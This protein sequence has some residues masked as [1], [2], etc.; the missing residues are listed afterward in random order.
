MKDL[1]DTESA[2]P[3]DSV[4]IVSAGE[5]VTMTGEHDR[6]E[7]IAVGGGQI[8]AV[9]GMRDLCM[10]FPSARRVEFSKRA[11]I[12]PGLN[13][14]HMHPTMY[15]E[16]RLHLRLSSDVIKDRDE[17]ASS[18]SIY[19]AQKQPGAWVK[20]F[21]YDHTKTTNGDVIDRAF[22]DSV[23]PDNPALVIH[24]SSHWAIAN[25]QALEAAGYD[26]SSDDPV[27]GTLGRDAGGRLNGVV[28]ENAL[29]HFLVSAP[30]L[31]WAG[32]VPEAPTDD[33]VES[34]RKLC[35]EF[36]AVGLTS[37][38]DAIVT[39]RNFSL[40][41]VA[42]RRSALSVRM[43]ALM[44]YPFGDSM[45]DLGIQHGFGSDWLRVHGIKIAVDGAITGGTCLLKEPFEG[46]GD[47]R[48]QQRMSAEE[49][50]SIVMPAHAAG[51]RLAFHANGDRAIE[52]VLDA[53]EKAQVATPND[54][55]H[56]IEHCT[57][58]DDSILE[59]MVKLNLIAVPFGAVLRYHG[60]KLPAW[61]G[62]ERLDRMFAHRSFIDHKIPVAGSS[63]F[64]IT[65]FDPR[66]ALQ[67]MVTRQTL[68][69]ETL[70]GSQ[71]I[72]PYE[73]LNVYTVGSAAAAGEESVKGQLRPGFLADFVVF[74]E[75]PLRVNPHELS[76]LPVL[77]TWVGGREVFRLGESQ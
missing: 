27:G 68:S 69:G 64:G 16:N 8:L 65:P 76:S 77:S 20:G 12:V 6:A 63:D 36:N 54:V 62:R 22:L 58:I 5:I 28:Y 45:I 14:A 11:C 26:D 31:G 10:Q 19:S 23:C 52:I 33:R 57:V 46:M 38:S 50:E 71:K 72:T 32:I 44:Y 73:A 42:E 48:G 59:R 34:L 40:L 4:S 56:R 25:T 35:A 53:I 51:I 75:S 1:E 66:L 21:Q 70:G 43:G 13:D 9:G 30:S 24:I 29:R 60:E 39:P 49:L 41:Q 47:F 74:A 55:R 61:Y 15:A 37:V 2:L 17:L 7:A 18:L 67:S 3:S